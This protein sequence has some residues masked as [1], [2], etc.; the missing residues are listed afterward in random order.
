[1]PHIG[2]IKKGLGIAD[3]QADKGISPGGGEGGGPHCITWTHAEEVNIE[4]VNFLGNA[5]RATSVFEK[6]AVA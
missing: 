4:L 2:E 1:M 3:R 6:E 5:K